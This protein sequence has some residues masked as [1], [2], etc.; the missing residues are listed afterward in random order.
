MRTIRREKYRT[1]LRNV[2]RVCNFQTTSPVQG[3]LGMG[4][5]ILNIFSFKSEIYVLSL[6]SSLEKK[7]TLRQFLIPTLYRCMDGL[8][9][10]DHLVYNSRH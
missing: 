2:E 8:D 4:R 1:A 6:T 10:S 5:W 7:K 3:Q 9:N